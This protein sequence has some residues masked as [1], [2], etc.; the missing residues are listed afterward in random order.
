MLKVA[1]RRMMRKMIGITLL[2]HRTNVWLENITKIP[3]IA[4]RATAIAMTEEVTIS[5]LYMI[6][7]VN[8]DTVIRTLGNVS[9][10]ARIV[11]ICLPEGV[12]K[13]RDFILAAKD[14]GFLTNEYVFIFA[15]TKSK[16]YSTPIAGGKERA[17]WVDVKA[18]NDGRD[19]EAK[20]AFGQ[21]LVIT[22]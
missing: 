10:R 4:A 21:T 17:I 3:D 8:S 7:D 20:K 14:G 12:G 9:T 15:D 11:V 22:D 19:E 13:K 5:A 6:R 2:D 16:G 1:Q 18:Q